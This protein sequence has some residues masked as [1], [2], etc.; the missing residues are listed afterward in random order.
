MNAN[1]G[2][3]SGI[4]ILD[5]A[6]F[7][8]APYAAS[9]LSEYGAEVIK[10]EQ[11]AGDSMRRIAPLRGDVSVWWKVIARNRKSVALDLN[12]DEGRD[13][14]RQLVAQCDI[15]ILN[16]RPSALKKWG[17]EFE[18]LVK[19]RKDLIFYHLT[20]YGEG[21][22]QQR[23]GF[24]RVAEAFAGLTNRTGFKDGP[25]VQS[26]YAMLG[27][28][29]AGIYGAFALMLALRQRDLTGEP[30]KIDLGLYEPILSMMEDMIVTYDETGSRMERMGNSSPRWSPH[31]LFQTRD[32][33]YAVI[34]CSTEKLWRQLRALI[35][36]EELKRYDDN[37]NL[38]V[39]ERPQLEGRIGEW[40]K[41]YTLSEL[42]DL[43]AN[44]GLA[45]GAIYS[46]EEIV[47]DP[48]II[49]RGS[50]IS[51]DDD[52]TGKPIRMASP[53]GRFSG[54]KGDVRTL[55]PRVGEHTDEILQ[56]LLGYSEGD[57]KALHEKQVVR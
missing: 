35:D 2:P 34:A 47:K 20:A 48:H 19:V 30:Q 36:D 44:A 25:P 33:L 1:K 28:G 16:F 3:L 56:D 18:D 38:R 29:I 14:F 54:F 27:D 4:R 31:G 41:G 51:L 10:V 21:P 45:I 42:L 22:Y 40:T 12:S 57:I 17:L 6:T 13:V 37:S 50:I 15:V 26:G 52:E 32:G 7:L 43:C 46:A 23:P 55:G 11:P 53:A 8:A 5:A 24:A 49:A 9:Q 39:S